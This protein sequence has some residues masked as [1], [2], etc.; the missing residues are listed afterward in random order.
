M[1]NNHIKGVFVVFFC[2][3]W[4]GPQNLATAQ[5]SI[6]H[7]CSIDVFCIIHLVLNLNLVLKHENLTDLKV[8][9]VKSSW[10]LD[11]LL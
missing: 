2:F 5:Q 10:K 1:P 8:D 3:F 11:G 9:Q 6:T 7:K 4:D